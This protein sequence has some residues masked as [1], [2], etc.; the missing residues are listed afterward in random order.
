MEVSVEVCTVYRVWALQVADVKKKVK[1]VEIVNT[2][3][4]IAVLISG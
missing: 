1:R 2:D 3:R 4:P